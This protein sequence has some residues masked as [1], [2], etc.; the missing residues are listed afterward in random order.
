MT[1]KRM[2]LLVLLL[3]IFMIIIQ[4]LMIKTIKSEVQSG[5]GTL[6]QMVDDFSIWG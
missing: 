2:I 4:L 1:E 6:Q 3:V 5:L